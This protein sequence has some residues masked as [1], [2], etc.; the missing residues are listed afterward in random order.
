MWRA[1]PPAGETKKGEIRVREGTP[2]EAA[3]AKLRAEF[4]RLSKLPD[5]LRKSEDEI[6]A[7]ARAA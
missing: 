1:T 6:W 5:S 4:T 7:M 2:Q 3:E